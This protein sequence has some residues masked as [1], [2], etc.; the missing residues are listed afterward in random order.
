MKTQKEKIALLEEKLCGLCEEDHS[1]DGRHEELTQ[2]CCD[3]EKCLHDK[4]NQ[5]GHLQRCVATG[6]MDG[7]G[8]DYKAELAVAR[9]DRGDGKR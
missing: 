7:T 5:I 6:R 9:K 3:L 1:E 4:D 8:T 2:K